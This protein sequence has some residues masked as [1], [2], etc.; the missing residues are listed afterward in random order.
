MLLS[1]SYLI[2][3]C[4]IRLFQ[5][6]ISN[7]CHLHQMPPISEVERRMYPFDW[8]QIPQVEM[9]VPE[10][11][12]V[13]YIPTLDEYRCRQIPAAYPGLG[14]VERRIEPGKG[15][16]LWSLRQVADG[17]N[18]IC[19]SIPLAK[20]KSTDIEHRRRFL[21]QHSDHFTVVVGKK[22]DEHLYAPTTG[23]DIHNGAGYANMANKGQT[24]N[25]RLGWYTTEDGETLACLR[26]L[27]GK[28]TKNK[29]LNLA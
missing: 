1:F 10:S 8:G 15:H 16:G 11:A 22:G 25:C 19:F 21:Q 6:D 18:I 2:S 7:V 9:K 5:H 27:E 24:R 17:E 20:I 14:L 4:L 3:K 29:W 12:V 13:Q 28:S 26:T 23:H